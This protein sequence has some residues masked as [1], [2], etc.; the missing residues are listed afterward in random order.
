MEVTDCVEVEGLRTAKGGGWDSRRGSLRAKRAGWLLR[1]GSLHAK[2]AGWLL[3]QG[4]LHAKRAGWLLRQGS[5]HAKGAG[6]VL[7][8]GSLHAR[9]AGGRC[10]GAVVDAA[11]A[12]GVAG[13]D[14]ER[15]AAEMPRALPRVSRQVED[16]RT[17]TVLSAPRARNTDVRKR[18]DIPTPDQP[19]RAI[20]RGGL[21]GYCRGTATRTGWGVPRPGKPGGV[22]VK[23]IRGRL[24]GGRG[25]AIPVRDRRKCNNSD[26]LLVGH[27]PFRGSGI[28]LSA[29][30]F[31]KIPNARKKKFPTRTERTRTSLRHPLG[32]RPQLPRPRDPTPFSLTQ[33][34][35]L[36]LL[37]RR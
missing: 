37:V 18:R 12:G 28:P 1:Q 23:L 32:T 34:A 2:R 31:A 13:C 33:G 36:H 5:L 25:P 9:E 22:F 19:D 14:R 21:T 27:L 16:L 17:S 30:R 7:R 15:A 8:Q 11:T 26:W 35:V 4:S 10:R 6:W 20:F 3:R 24:M 29:R